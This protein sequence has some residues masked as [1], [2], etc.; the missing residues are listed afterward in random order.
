MMKV[1]Y[2][3]VFILFFALPSA[4][5]SGQ[6]SEP[7]PSAVNTLSAEA[8][9]LALTFFAYDAQIPLDP[10]TLAIDTFDH[11][12]RYKITLA[13]VHGGKVPGYVAIPRQGNGPFPLVLLLHGLGG[14]K[15]DWW[16]NEDYISGGEMSEALLN[17]GMAVLTLDAA[18]HGERIW[19]NDYES[20]G[21]MVFQ[22]GEFFRFRDVMV[23]TVQEYRRALD[24]ASSLPN[25][26]PD[27]FAVQGYSMG[28]MMTYLL[29][30]VEPRLKTAVACVAP[31]LAD[32]RV[33]G[34]SPFYMAPGIRIPFKAIS[35]ENDPFYSQEEG[36]LLFDQVTSS[37]KDITWYDCDHR[38]PV[39][40]V[41]VAK[42][43]LADHLK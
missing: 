41:D 43:W 1:T 27:R 13:T 23:Q 35:G 11:S 15:E 42:E 6:P 9:D 14:S 39:E 28:G 19:Q 2:P 40:Y 5:L 30:A 7:D 37:R 16:I 12:I 4:I 18:L 10:D 22:R 3:W 32:P 29:S 8:R 24:Y 17:E 26:D 33:A 34:A 36:Q 31:P 21:V 38:L 20:P 25:I